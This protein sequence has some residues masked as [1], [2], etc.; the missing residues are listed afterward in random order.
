MHTPTWNA[1]Q[2][3][4]HPNM[5]TLYLFERLQYTHS[6]EQCKHD[7]GPQGVQVWHK[8]D[9]C[10][11]AKSKVSKCVT[12]EA[13]ENKKGVASGEARERQKKLRRK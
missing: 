11:N 1:L 9:S 3:Y 2:I 10:L 5:S 6:N 4:Q 12:Q 13:A 7:T 8:M